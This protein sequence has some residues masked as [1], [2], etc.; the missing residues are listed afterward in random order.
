MKEKVNMKTTEPLIAYHN[1]PELKTMM[2]EEAARHREQDQIVKGTYQREGK[3]GKFQGCA[4]GCTIHS[5]NVRLGKKLP[6]GAHVIYETELGVP[7]RL[8]R[9]E[10]FMFERLPDD[11]AQTWPQRFLEAIPVGADLSGVS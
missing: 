4:V 6:C 3:D 8:A 2:V 7:Y 10:D 11:K 1:K 5:L 9:L